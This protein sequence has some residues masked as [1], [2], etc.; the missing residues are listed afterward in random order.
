MNL[1]RAERW[2]GNLRHN[3][4]QYLWPQISRSYCLSRIEF[5]VRFVIFMNRGYFSKRLYQKLFY[6]ELFDIDESAKYEMVLT[7]GAY[8]F[9]LDFIIFVE[10][11]S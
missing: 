2:R 10:F 6:K 1:N 5:S 8:C 4:L 3:D 9:L 7:L 11:R